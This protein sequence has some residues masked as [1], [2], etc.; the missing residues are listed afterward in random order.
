VL[1]EGWL[2]ITKQQWYHDKW[3]ADET[4]FQGIKAQFPTVESLAWF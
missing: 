3:L 1:Y 2:E 4:Y